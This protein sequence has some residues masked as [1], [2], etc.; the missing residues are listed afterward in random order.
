MTDSS[1]ACRGIAAQR[2]TTTG[3]VVFRRWRSAIGANLPKENQKWPTSTATFS[4][5][6]PKSSITATGPNTRA[7]I[8]GPTW[9]AAVHIATPFGGWISLSPTRNGIPGSAA[10]PNAVPGPT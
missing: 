7:I 3:D 4:V 5:A 6:Y 9:G 8:G 1:A 2:A 10:T